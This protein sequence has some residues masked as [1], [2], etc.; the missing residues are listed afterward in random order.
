MYR[1]FHL[2]TWVNKGGFLVFFTLVNK[3]DRVSLFSRMFGKGVYNFKVTSN[4]KNIKVTSNLSRRF[5]SG[6]FK[7]DAYGIEDCK[8][9]DGLKIRS[10]TI[11]EEFL[12]VSDCEDLYEKAETFKRIIVDEAKKDRGAHK[13]K[14]CKVFWLEVDKVDKRELYED[15]IYLLNDLKSV[16]KGFINELDLSKYPVI[17]ELYSGFTCHP[18]YCSGK[19]TFEAYKWLFNLLILNLYYISLSFSDGSDND[20]EVDFKVLA[21][22]LYSK[23]DSS[24]RK[25]LQKR[26]ISVIQN[27]YTGFDTEYVNKDKKFNNLLSVQLAVNTDILLKVPFRNG[28]EIHQVNPKTNEEYAY[29][30]DLNDYAIFDYNKVNNSI[31]YLIKKIR[32]LRCFEYDESTDVLIAGF[33]GKGVPYI[34]KEN[35]IIFKFNRTPIE[36]FIYFNKDKKGYSL[37]EILFKSNS[38]A[39]RWLNETLEEILDMLKSFYNWHTLKDDKLIKSKYVTGT[40]EALKGSI[41]ESYSVDFNEDDIKSKSK[42]RS[43]MTSFTSDKISVTKKRYNYL[44][45]HLTNADLSILNDFEDFKDFLNIVNKSF[46]TLGKPFEY[47]GCNVIIRDTMLLSPAA[48]KSLDS[49][50]RLYGPGFEKVDLSKEVKS[51]MSLLLKRDKELFVKY[52]VNDALI[53]LVHANN[54]QDF[55][56]ELKGVGMPITLSNISKRYILSEWSKKGYTGY[57]VSRKFLIGDTSSFSTPKGLIGNLEPGLRLNYY[58]ANY[59]GG[60]NE[61]FMYGVDL[62]TKWFDYDLISA[63][64][65]VMSACGNPKYDS[66][67]FLSESDLKGMSE[68]DI[69]Y[70]YI[71]IK[72]TFEFNEGTKYPSIA[73]YLDENTTVYPLKGEAV[74]TGSE[75][76][77]AKR[78]GC[79]LNIKEIFYIPF[80]EDKGEG[81]LKNQPFEEV[82][83][84]LQFKRSQHDKGTLRNALFKQILNS[85]YGLIVRGIND[86]RK[87]DLKTGGTVRMEAG[88]FSNPIIGSWI[89]AFV[90]SVIG[91]CLHNL[92]EN[93]KKVVSVT[94]DGFVTEGLITDLEVFTEGNYLLSEFRRIRY[95]LSGSYSGLEVKHEGKGIIS[96]TTRGQLSVDAKIKATTGFQARDYSMQEMETLFVDTLASE[97]KSLEYIQKSLRSAKDIYKKGGH[98]TAL[99]KD[100]IFRLHY[101]NRR[102]IQIPEDLEVFDVTKNLLDS[103]PV[104]TKE[105]A[106]NLRSIGKMHKTVMYNKLTTRLKGN[107]YKDYTDLAIRNFIK[108]IVNDSKLFNLDGGLNT[109][110]EIID[111]IQGYKKNARVSKHSISKL[112]NRK[113][114]LKT[115]PRTEETLKFVEYVKSKFKSFDSEVFFGSK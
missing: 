45:A 6:W 81:K 96:W 67:C 62:N 54:M 95:K 115:V 73:C 35:T 98:V 109:Y 33:M 4:L 11:K 49:I 105:V 102:I 46:I 112:K 82:V 57:Q 39:E 32:V 25:K 24:I 12:D 43:Y 50:G 79:K 37:K 60:R 44:I 56:F 106:G 104:K 51:D 107:E 34:I 84:D 66:G 15:I 7:K 31:D 38:L 89:T 103:M 97:D 22:Q 108:I 76:L 74:L 69:L 53:T 64:T 47:F 10:F 99:Y 92:A 19:K 87:Y 93:D 26:G 14:T 78:Q 111:F 28:Y 86:K 61:S 18:D 8:D 80:E 114:I 58:I 42:S 63:Y 71:I 40:G 75:Y 90:R 2:W 29:D 36:R 1:I 23:L 3:G 88:E 5:Y 20:L 27:V 77:L 110:A 55:F 101:D 70:S 30:Y 16:N 72:C 48:N 68:S 65:T 94:T 85:M 21:D 59:K 9:L 41:I 91:E 13:K 100:Q 83:K 17:S 52:A 113:F